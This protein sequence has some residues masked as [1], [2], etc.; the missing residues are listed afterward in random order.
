MIDA[1]PLLA[2]AIAL[3]LSLAGCGRK[4]QQE[5]APASGRVLEGTISDAMIET[6][7]LRSEGPFKAPTS[8][9]KGEKAKGE[10]KETGRPR[11][12]ATRSPAR[13]QASPTARPAPSPAA[14]AAP[15]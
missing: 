2:V 1:Y 3:A 7:Q 6:D 14:E 12:A 11:S 8:P 13:T 4:A 5:E 10:T 15:D 9:T